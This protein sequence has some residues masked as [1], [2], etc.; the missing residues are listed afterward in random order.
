MACRFFLLCCLVHLG[1][2]LTS[3]AALMTVHVNCSDKAV[4]GGSALPSEYYFTRVVDALEAIR[5]TRRISDIAL[6]PLPA[7]ILITGKCELSQPLLL[8]S[9]Q[10]SYITF[11]GVP[12]SGAM[13]SAGVQLPF[14]AMASGNYGKGRSGGTGV[15]HV[16]LSKLNFTQD[17]LGRLKAFF[18]LSLLWVLYILS[19]DVSVLYVCINCLVRDVATLEAVPVS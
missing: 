19:P 3:K 8:E 15:V 18:F 1:V 13:L 11:R 12:G 4:L 5:Q 14:P 2:C 16:D 9:M 7:V 10:G 6:P 17:S